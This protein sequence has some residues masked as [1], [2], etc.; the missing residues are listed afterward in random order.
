MPGRVVVVADNPETGSELI[1]SV[2]VP[3]GYQAEL[4]NGANSR[5]D[6]LIVDIARLRGAPLARLRER[7][8]AGD[9]APAILLA[10]HL[11]DDLASE[12]FRLNV[13]DFLIKPVQPD[14]LLVSLQSLLAASAAQTRESDKL[15][16][17]NAAMHRRL[18]DWRSAISIGRAVVQIHDLDTLLARIVEAAVYLTGAEEGALYLVEPVSNDLVLRAS[19]DSGQDQAQSLRLRAPDSIATEVLRS[20][21]PAMRQAGPRQPGLK[22]KTGHLVHA[23]INLPLAVGGR[24]IGVLGVYHRSRGRTFDES[25]AEALVFLADWA[26]IAIES[27]QRFAELHARLEQK[28]EALSRVRAA[29]AGPGEGRRARVAVSPGA[30]DDLHSRLD[31]LSDEITRLLAATYGPLRPA[32]ADCLASLH[33]QADEALAL[34]ESLSNGDAGRAT[35]LAG[36]AHKEVRS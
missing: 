12:V 34:V 36:P 19:R 15:A 21:A 23:L 6:V 18:E 3:A 33:Q 16:A 25:Q 9:T 1:E 24:P 4:D 35:P 22:V 27:A 2:L 20:G 10:A 17:E 5:A 8:E 14:S 31:A 29:A 32:Q 11:P 7:R 30:L 13:V 26:A 28:T